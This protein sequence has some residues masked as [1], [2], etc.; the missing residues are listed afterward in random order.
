MAD[1]GT[2]EIPRQKNLVFMFTQHVGAINFHTYM[3][4]QEI[5][6]RLLRDR[7]TMVYAEGADDA[8][9]GKVDQWFETDGSGKHEIIALAIK[10]AVSGRVAVPGHQG[11]LH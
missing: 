3:T 9:A 11:A 8:G 1:K 10:M 2:L 5:H 7:T 6:D 4:S